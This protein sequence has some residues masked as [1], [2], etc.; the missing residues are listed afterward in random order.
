MEVYLN[1][2]MLILPSEWNNEARHKIR[3]YCA[4][5]YN[6]MITDDQ[7]HMIFSA[8]HKSSYT[9]EEYVDIGDIVI[10]ED[11]MMMY[12]VPF[13]LHNV[14]NPYDGFTSFN[15]TVSSK[16][17]YDVVNELC[18][19]N[20][21][22][23]LANRTIFIYGN[24]DP[25][26]RMVIQMMVRYFEFVCLNNESK[27]CVE[28]NDCCLLAMHNNYGLKYVKFFEQL[29]FDWNILIKDTDVDPIKRIVEKAILLQVDESLYEDYCEEADKANYY[30]ECKRK[31]KEDTYE[32]PLKKIDQI[33]HPDKENEEETGVTED[34]LELMYMNYSTNDSFDSEAAKK[35]MSE[36]IEQKLKDCDRDLTKYVLK[37]IAKIFLILIGA[38][39]AIFLVLTL[40]MNTVDML[41][42][43]IVDLVTLVIVLIMIVSVLFWMC[44]K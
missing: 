44:G 39:I 32:D 35:E 41:S 38:S 17:V 21:I 25:L 37:Y 30:R 5:R 11:E 26:M 12:S 10:D 34:N 14:K 18:G 20:Q 29:L 3:V 19:D 7:N 33:M 27:N 2:N 43:M 24:Q 22:F 23:I 28:A 15:N 6:T 13:Y 8:Y 4:L 40:I 16:I 1:S 9:N 31:K 36:R 42:G